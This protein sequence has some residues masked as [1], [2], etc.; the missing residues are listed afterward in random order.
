MADPVTPV[1]SPGTDPTGDVFQIASQPSNIG[2]LKRAVQPPSNVYIETTDVLVVGCATTQTGEMLTVSYRFL[3]FDGVVIHG[4][5]TISPPSNRAVA[6]HSEQ[7]AEGF[8]LS[9]SCKA[10]IAIS[11]G[12]T[13]VRAFLTKPSLG[14]GQPSYMLMADYVTTAMAP[15]FPNGRV[16][17][18]SEGPGNITGVFGATPPAGSDWLITVPA[19]TRWKVLQT[20]SSFQASA[21]V[22]NRL[23]SLQAFVFGFSTFVGEASVPVPA[24]GSRSVLSWPSSAYTPADTNHLIVSQQPDLFMR[25]GNTIESFT[26][27]I[28]AGDQWGGV[29][30]LVEEWLDNV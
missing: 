13:F 28:Q 30:M 16:L 4:Q 25:S 3:R 15:A 23:I 18:P 24:S 9:M 20:S 26:V 6:I 11:R 14:P 17:A 21:A 2:F 29:G 12:Q 7:L 10:T 19:N 1:L 22:A 8:L 5:F 27:G